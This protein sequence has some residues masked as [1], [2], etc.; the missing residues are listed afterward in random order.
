MALDHDDRDGINRRHALHRMIS[1]GAASVADWQCNM[2][3]R[4]VWMVG[5]YLKAPTVRLDDRPTNSK[6][7]THSAGLCRKEGLENTVSVF[8]IYS[9]SRI[10]DGDQ[11]VRRLPT[12]I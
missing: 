10:L 11:N 2:K 7:N 3:D 9:G 1:V 4:P 8:P 12:N 5:R 6:S